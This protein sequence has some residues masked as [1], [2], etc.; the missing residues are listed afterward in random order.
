MSGSKGGV[1]H[2]CF[3]YFVPDVLIFFMNLIMFCCWVKYANGRSESSRHFLGTREHVFWDAK[4]A[5]G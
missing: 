5:S 2:L 4:N 1:T 3:E